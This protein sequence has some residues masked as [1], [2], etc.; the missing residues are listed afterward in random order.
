[1]NKGRFIRSLFYFD[2]FSKA[3]IDYTRS[4][5]ATCYQVA[6]FQFLKG[7]CIG[8]IIVLIH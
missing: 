4:K 7:Y 8:N 1:M 2:N 6:F 5:K 3:G